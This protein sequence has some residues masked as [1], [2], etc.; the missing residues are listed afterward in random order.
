MT[1][2]EMTRVFFRDMTD[3]EIRAYIATGEPMDK[4]GAYG[5]QGVAG[6]FIQGIEGDFFNVVG[7][8]LCRL[9]QMLRELGVEL[10]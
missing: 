1:Q 6:M 4:A 3:R 7:L 10:L 5:Y 8:P 2:T 9:G